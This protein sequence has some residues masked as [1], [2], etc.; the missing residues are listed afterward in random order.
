LEKEAEERR[1][2]EKEVAKTHKELLVAS[3]QAGMAEVATNVLHN[4]GNVL[5]SVNISATVVAGKIKKSKALNIARVSA[6]IR[7]HAGNL[8]D[9]FARDPKGRQLPQYVDNLAEHLAG[10]QAS[11]LTEIDSLQKNVEHIKNIVSMQQNYA[12]VSGVVETVKITDLVE[13][14]VNMN[15]GALSRHEVQ[16]FRE[17]EPHLPE[18]SVE[19]H[20]IL[21]I[22]VNL[23]RNAKYACDESG[24]A[25]KH[26][27][28]RVTNGDDYLRVAVIDNGVGIPEA[29]LIKIFN[30]G[31]TT[32]KDGH[33]FGLHSGALAAKE[34]GGSLSAQSEGPGKGATFTLA[35]PLRSKEKLLKAEFSS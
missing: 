8:A 32:R 23:I 10:E 26:M 31:F 25:E 27:T 19:K 29:N 3:R 4:V 2:M 21:Q 18:I 5:N 12:K 24:H 6:L 16:L 33:G 14:A 34:L 17:Y 15:A 28:V 11:L 30:H 22:L 13:D 35:L 20:K 7:E 9:F 1:R